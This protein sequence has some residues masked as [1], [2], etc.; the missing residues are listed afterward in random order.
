MKIDKKLIRDLIF[1]IA[2]GIG[3][4]F[5]LKLHQDRKY[6]IKPIEIKQPKSCTN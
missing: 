5:I 3:A 1:V 2:I 6:L 4:I